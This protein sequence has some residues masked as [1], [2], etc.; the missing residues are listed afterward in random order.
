MLRAAWIVRD[1]PQLEVHRRLHFHPNEPGLDDA[2]LAFVSVKAA[3][4]RIVSSDAMPA[5]PTV[6]CA[7]VMA[8]VYEPAIIHSGFLPI[9]TST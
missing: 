4:R 3:S 5:R 2:A 8:D 9:A 7:A 1:R 6:L